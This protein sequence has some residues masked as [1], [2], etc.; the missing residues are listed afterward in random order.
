MVFFDELKYDVSVY[1]V[2]CLFFFDYDVE[3][4]KVV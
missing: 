3:K 2:F 4:V 1:G